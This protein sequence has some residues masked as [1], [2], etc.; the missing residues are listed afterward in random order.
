MSAWI[1][2]LLVSANHGERGEKQ[3]DKRAGLTFDDVLQFEVQ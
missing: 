3:V 2:V 1:E